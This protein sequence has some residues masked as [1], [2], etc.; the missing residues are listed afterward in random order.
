[1]I[2]IIGALDKELEYLFDVFTMEKTEV[3]ADKVLYIGKLYG[4]EAVIAKS[5]IGKVNAALTTTIVCD[6]FHPEYVLNIG[7]AGG[8][9]D[10]KTGDIVLARGIAYFDVS[11]SDIDPVP[12]GKMGDDPLLLETDPMLLEVAKRAIEKHGIGHIMGNI[13]SG[14]RFVVKMSTLH[15]IMKE[16]DDVVAC[17]MEGMAVGMVCHKF[18][19]PFLSIRGVSDI[20]EDK[21]QAQKYKFSSRD[22]ARSTTRFVMAFLEEQNG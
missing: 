12:F 6:R 8:I 15:E 13:V 22:V 3:V 7:V 17:E 11:V 19:I 14:D 2:A 5:G 21:D 20:L 9:G 10:T 1:M 18:G 4:R 16:I